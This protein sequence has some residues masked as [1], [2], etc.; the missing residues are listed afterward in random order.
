[1]KK[2]ETK[3]QSFAA[4]RVAFSSLLCM[5]LCTMCFCSSSWAWFTVS[6]SCRIDDVKAAEYTAIVSLNEVARQSIEG[7]KNKYSFEIKD[8][9]ISVPLNIKITIPT[10]NTSAKGYVAW[11]YDGAETTLGKSALT[12]NNDITINPT[13]SGTLIF[14]II[15]GEDSTQNS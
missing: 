10:D 14:E 11:Y 12:G 13:R 9:N 7:E 1:M 5:A 3:K 2:A 15:W 4:Y 8:A 6:K